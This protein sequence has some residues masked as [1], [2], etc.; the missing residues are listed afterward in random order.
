[1]KDNQDRNTEF[2]NIAC[3]RVD[4]QIIGNPIMSMATKKKEYVDNFCRDELAYTRK[5]LLACDYDCNCFAD[6]VIIPTCLYDVLHN[7]DYNNLDI[8]KYTNEFACD[9]LCYW[10]Q[11]QVDYPQ[12]TSILL[13][14]DGGGSN[15]QHTVNKIGIKICIAHYPSI[16]PRLFP[17]VTRAC[18]DVLYKSIELVKQLMQGTQTQLRLNISVQI[19][20]KIYQTAHKVT[21][22]FKQT[23]P[24]VFNGYLLSCPIKC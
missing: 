17:H 3:L 20:D 11:G 21:D 24:I 5:T 13:L 14:W 23:I 9:S 6:E 12:A 22:K 4:Y 19:I 15:N 1:M 7:I 8:S 18:Q 16:E 2:E 10:W